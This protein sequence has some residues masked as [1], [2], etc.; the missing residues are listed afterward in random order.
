MKRRNDKLTENQQ[1]LLRELPDDQFKFPGRL[2]QQS[3]QKLERLGFAESDLMNAK[4]DNVKGTTEFRL[5]FKRTQ[6]GKTIAEG[7]P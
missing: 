1:R 6:A 3:Y 2:E 7:K 4:R 5:A